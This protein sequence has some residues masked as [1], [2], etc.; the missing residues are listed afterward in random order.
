MIM[1]HEQAVRLWLLSCT[2]RRCR[3]DSLAYFS[4]PYRLS[5][6]EQSGMLASTHLV[7]SREAFELKQRYLDIL[8]TFVSSV[9]RFGAVV[10]VTLLPL[11]NRQGHKVGDMICQQQTVK[12]E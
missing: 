6:L 1:K 7:E 3:F 11:S 8:G 2:A 12:G 5:A 10:L 4:S 9:K